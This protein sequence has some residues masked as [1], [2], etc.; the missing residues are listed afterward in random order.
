MSL[1]LQVAFVAAG[2]A[3][4][5]YGKVLK[6]NLGMSAVDMATFF[7][8]IKLLHPVVH[9]MLSEMC[10]EAK[11]EM[12]ALDP[13]ALGSWQRAITRCMAY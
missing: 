3:H 7:D 11:A 4:A 10:E 13:T 5:Q 6:Q 8:T 9:K 1:A 2:C 12:K